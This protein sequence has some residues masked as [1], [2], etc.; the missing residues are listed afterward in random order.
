MLVEGVVSQCVCEIV[1]D[2][3]ASHNLLFWSHDS[4]IKMT[5]LNEL[6]LITDRSK[7]VNL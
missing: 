6:I 1:W 2:H 7:T 3:G 4:N 5:Q